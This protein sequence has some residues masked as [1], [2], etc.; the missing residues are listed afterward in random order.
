MIENTNIPDHVSEWYQ[1]QQE[2]KKKS[3]YTKTEL[4][5]FKI[6]LERFLLKHNRYPLS[7][8]RRAE[9]EC[10]ASQMTYEGVRVYTRTTKVGKVIEFLYSEC[11]RELVYSHTGWRFDKKMR[12]VTEYQK[13][14]KRHHISLGR[15]LLGN[16][17]RM[18]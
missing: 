7:D 8:R 18:E 1:K 2:S 11:D 4:E 6:D 17:P 13:D 14:F 5:A 16:P 15:L 9:I 10:E 3:K 12:I